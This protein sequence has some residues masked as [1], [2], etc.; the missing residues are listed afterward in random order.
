MA[1]NKSNYE[2]RDLVRAVLALHETGIG[3]KIKLES[4]AIVIEPAGATKGVV[5][6]SGHVSGQG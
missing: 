1:K 3:G 4:G 2:M 6:E 5:G